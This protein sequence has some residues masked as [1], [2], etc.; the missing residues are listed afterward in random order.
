MNTCALTEREMED[1]VLDTMDLERERGITIKA[2]A[3]RMLYR[4]KDGE[5]Y[6]LNLIDTP[7]HVDFNYEVS[8]SI[9]ACE[10]AV[11]VVD[12]SQG[13]EAQTLANV[14]LALEQNLEIVPVINKIDL[15]SARP[16]E[17]KQEIEDV[18]GIDCSDA[19]LISAK[20]GINIEAVL[21]KIVEMVPPPTGEKEAPLRALIFD[22]LYD[23]YKGVIAHVRIKEGSVK[24]GQEILL[25][26][27]NKKFIVTELGYFR[28]GGL[29]P[30]EA[31]HSGDVGFI[32]ADMLLIPV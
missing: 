32:C 2:Q 20:N 17:V 5:E 4:A 23:N 21:E 9:A 25:M 24:A 11:L 30:A 1:R 16:D 22:S 8:R 26:H 13:I 12:A 7:G 6:I 18:I 31:L 28:P 3:S 15:P 19:P 27:T 14:Y 29:I 10:G